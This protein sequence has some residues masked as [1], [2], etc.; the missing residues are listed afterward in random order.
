MMILE[1]L[2]L[3][4]ANERMK[5]LTSKVIC[6]SACAGILAIIGVVM[7]FF[8]NE[9]KL[10]EYHT[11]ASSS[12]SSDHKMVSSTA[13]KVM[14]GVVV[15]LLAIAVPCCGYCGARHNNKCA[16]GC[17]SCCNCV[18][19]CLNI[20]VVM[21]CV[22]GMVGLGSVQDTCRPTA[23]GTN[24]ECKGI[25]QACENLKSDQYQLDTYEGCYDYMMAS[26]PYVYG[27]LAFVIA[28]KCCTVGLECCSA[29][30]GKELYDELDNGEC[31][32]ESDYEDNKA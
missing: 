19:G 25:M 14:G 23:G 1:P 9:E 24:E 22:I 31:L 29:Y 30:Y 6:L 18:G 27:V 12:L 26:Y 2:H 11:S 8:S 21:T 4:I 5:K 7:S 17:F 3:T 32:H 10:E 20:L 16:I 13:V 28:L 15:V